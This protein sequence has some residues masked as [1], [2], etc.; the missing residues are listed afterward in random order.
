M[1]AY[2]VAY[3]DQIGDDTGVSSPVTAVRRKPQDMRT[4]RG[5]DD[6]VPAWWEYRAM[7]RQLVSLAEAMNGYRGFSLDLVPGAGCFTD[8]ARSRTVI[9]PEFVRYEDAVEQYAVVLGCLGHESGHAAHTTPAYGMDDETK[10]SPQFRILAKICNILEDQRIEAAIMD[11]NWGVEPYIRL[12]HTRLWEA[13]ASLKGSDDPAEVL[14][15]ILLIRFGRRLKGSLSPANK[16][17]LDAC[18][19][20]VLNAWYGEDSHAVRRSAIEIMRV[21]GLDKKTTD[22]QADMLPDQSCRRSMTGR[23]SDEASEN[24]SADKN[25]SGCPVHGKPQPD[26][27]QGDGGRSG[28]AQDGKPQPNEKQDGAGQCDGAQDGAG[29][30]GGAQGQPGGAQDGA[31]QSDGTQDGAGQSDGTQ[32]GAGQPDGTQDGA[33]QPGGAQGGAGRVDG[34]QSG[35]APG[36]AQDGECSCGKAAS[37]GADDGDPDDGRYNPDGRGVLDAGEVKQVL[38]DAARDLARALGTGAGAG[39]MGQPEMHHRPIGDKVYEDAVA[40]SQVLRRLLDKVPPEMRTFACA[41]GPRYSLRD[42]LRHPDRP[43][44]RREM[45]AR[46]KRNIVGVLSD[47]SGS[48]GDKIPLVHD[49]VLSVYLA[50]SGLGVPLPVWAFSSWSRPAAPVV[51]P[52]DADPRT[53][54]EAIAGIVAVGSTTLSPALREVSEQFSAIPA[55]RRVLL[56]IHDGAPSDKAEAVREIEKMR[57]SI[58]VIGIFL[59]KRAESA[60]LI[61][62]MTGIFGTRLI[63]AEDADELMG[64]LGTFLLRLLSPSV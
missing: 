7:H 19:P 27:K 61:A 47:C 40:R 46:P 24:P 54:P 44:R 32:D 21:L 1:S 45:P 6:S 26:E 5:D 2:P 12:V 18:W 41:D 16:V 56:V 22:E 62:A 14:R 29:Q 58:D 52:A 63:V 10:A 11:E 33:E 30:P 43:M 60:K 42:D 15:A 55:D 38:E 9:D 25:P 35:E 36:E 39:D 57:R 37:G 31:G 13:S 20:H 8:L 4:R 59:G 17:L 48:M 28:N 53:A 49:A 23:R 51:L 34:A 50:A 3:I 64:L